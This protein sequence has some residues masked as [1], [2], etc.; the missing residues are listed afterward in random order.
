MAHVSDSSSALKKNLVNL[1]T[2]VEKLDISNLTPVPD[3]LAKL[4]NVVKTDAV[5]KTEYNKLV[6]QVDNID[7]TGFV[8]KT[9]YDTDKSDLEKKISDDEKKISNTRAFV[10][11][12]YYS[13][14]ITEIEN[15]IPSISGLVT[16]SALTA[17]ESKIPNASGL[18]TKTD[19]ST[20]INE[21]EKKITDHDH[22]EYIQNYITS[23]YITNNRKFE[24][25]AS[26]RKC[27]D[28]NRF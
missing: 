3:D 2:E 10:K 13:S 1:K 21:I 16:N 19:Y 9:K 18:V 14:K 17:V 5:K 7:A 23:N 28:K 20:K 27:N 26:T 4:S 12:T 22:D 11:K 15:K 24:S 6:T 25:K 8:L